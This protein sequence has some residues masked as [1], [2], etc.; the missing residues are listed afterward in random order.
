MIVLPFAL[1]VSEPRLILTC[2]PMFQTAMVMFE[3]DRFLA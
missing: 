2:R 1:H 3:L